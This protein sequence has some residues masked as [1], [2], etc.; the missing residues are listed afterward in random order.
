MY[1]VL[2]V[3]A[4][5]RAVSAV[6]PFKYGVIVIALS[7]FPP[8]A[9]LVQVTVTSFELVE[10]VAVPI[11]GTCGFVVAVTAAAFE[12]LTVVPKLFCAFP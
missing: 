5:V 10:A 8:V 11:V 6:V 12:V 9:P 3:V 1:E 4:A 7:A 2:D